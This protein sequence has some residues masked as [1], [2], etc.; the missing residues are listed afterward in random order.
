MILPIRTSYQRRSTPWLNYALIAANVLLYVLGYNASTPAHSLRISHWMLSPDMP[1]LWQFISCLFLHASFM[2]LAGNM[3]FL[4]VFGNAVNDKL[5]TT[6]YLAFYLGGGVLACIGYLL[7]G[8]ANPVLGASGAIAAV[9]GA[10]LVLLPRTRI[11]L[12]VWVVYFILPL[13]ISSLYF[14]AMQFAFEMLMSAQGISGIGETG[15]VAYTAHA[16]GYLFGILVSGLLLWTRALPHDDYNLFWMIRHRHRRGAYREAV[17]LGQNPFHAPPKPGQP[18]VLPPKQRDPAEM[19]LR[20]KITQAC[21]AHEMPTAAALYLEFKEIAEV[22]VL[23]EQQQIDV[24]HHFMASACYDDAAHAYE[25]YVKHYAHNPR[26]ADIYLMLGLLYS[27]YLHQAEQAEAY[28][29]L[30]VARLAD[31][32]KRQTAEKALADLGASPPTPNTP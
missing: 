8:G 19:A 11:T 6:G 24:A 4:W 32:D 12:I 21:R 28:L 18:S 30:A 27:R 5:G 16:S 17:R 2:H 23:P 3:I 31:S 13:D 10:Y 29:T 7:L 22:P 14:I 26:I 15:S 20:E 25:R 1:E 9:T